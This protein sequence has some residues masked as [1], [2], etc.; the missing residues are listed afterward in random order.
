M[1]HLYK[2]QLQEKLVYAVLKLGLWLPWGGYNRKR[3][4]EGA[5]GVPEIPVSS[6]GAGCVGTV[7]LHSWAELSV[8]VRVLPVCAF[9][10]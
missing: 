5:P 3:K 7:A 2:A 9:S 10:F 4:Q 1:I 6:S 8:C